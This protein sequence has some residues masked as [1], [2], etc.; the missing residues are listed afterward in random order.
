MSSKKAAFF[1]GGIFALLL[2]TLLILLSP[3]AATAETFLEKVDGRV[4]EDT[5]DEQTAHF[6]V[7]LKEQADVSGAADL[8]TKEEKGA[9]VTNLLRET[10]ART[11]PAVTGELDKLRASYRTY[12]I[13]NMIAVKGDRQAVEAMARHQAI[14]KVGTNRTMKLEEEPKLTPAEQRIPVSPSSVEWGVEKIGAPDV[15]TMGYRGSGIVVANQDTGV[16]WDH[17]AL[18]KQYRGSDESGETVDHNYHWWDAIHE[19]LDGNGSNSCGFSSSVPCGDLSHG[20]HTV[21]TA[22]GDDGAGNQIGVAPDAKWIGC[23]NMESGTGRP[24]TYTECF[25]FFMAPHDLNG[26]N[27]DPSLAP[28]VISNSWG[29]P[30]GAPPGGE[31]CEVASFNTTIQNMRAAGIMVVVSNGNN[32][33]ACSS[34]LSPPGYIDAATSVGATSSTD[35]IAS[36]SSR[37]PVTADGSNRIKPDISA[38]GL[39]V[40][41]STRG[42]SYGNSSGTSMAAPHVA[43][44]VALLLDARPA[45][46]GN[47]DGIEYALFS[48][49]VERTTEENCGGVPGTNVPNNT[50]GYGR[51]DILSAVNATPELTPSIS[52][53][54]TVGTDPSTCADSDRI[55]VPFGSYVTYCYTVKNTGQITFTSHTLVDDQV[56]TLLSNHTQVLIPGATTFVTVT[57]TTI[58]PTRGYTATWSATGSNYLRANASASVAFTMSIP[59]AISLSD[60]EVTPTHYIWYF[61]LPL[62]MIG[63]I[64]GLGVLLLYRHRRRTS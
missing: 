64:V 22:V 63:M 47:V 9:Y 27:P 52:L 56:G 20:T 14:A 50:F 2:V 48:T 62:S 23:R 25:Q 45:L 29:C 18:V 21:G 8:R 13:S 43:G 6:L 35:A 30:F 60:V 55:E 33:S 28:D 34:T 40:R 12:W 36:F 26:E 7:I 17:P 54:K 59:T 24:S 4:L 31:E 32:G 39:S 1:T 5:E 16:Q 42:N 57:T 37:G 53:T 61:A 15:W 49:A 46:R 19:D 38:P 51:L 44:A 10:A 58:T 11:Q 41:S 3:P